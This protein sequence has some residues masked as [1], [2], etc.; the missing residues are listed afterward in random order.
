MLYKCQGR[1]IQILLYRS[2]ASQ[3]LRGGFQHRCISTLNKLFLSYFQGDMWLVTDFKPIQIQLS[4]AC[5][6]KLKFV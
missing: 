2:V 6:L 4:E 3:A 5:M 1:N